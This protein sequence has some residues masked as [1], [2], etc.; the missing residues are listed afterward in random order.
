MNL[1]KTLYKEK[2]SRIPHTIHILGDSNKKFDYPGEVILSNTDTTKK[3]IVIAKNIA[4]PTKI[5]YSGQ[6]YI[7]TAYNKA[8]INKTNFEK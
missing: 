6:H 4:I 7:E 1:E 2:T 5:K 3:S 8:D